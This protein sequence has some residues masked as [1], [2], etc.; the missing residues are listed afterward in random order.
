MPTDAFNTDRDRPIDPTTLQPAV[1]PQPAGQPG[2]RPDPGATPPAAATSSQQLFTQPAA[3]PTTGAQRI[4]AQ[5][6]GRQPTVQRAAPR[7]PLRVPPAFVVLLVLNLV[8]ALAGCAI[9]VVGMFQEDADLE[10]LWRLYGAYVLGVGLVGL[11][12]LLP[13]LAIIQAIYRAAEHVRGGR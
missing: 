7:R 10:Q 9:I 12:L 8:V 11:F 1:P 6:T 4:A 3:A 2:A 13:L 5:A